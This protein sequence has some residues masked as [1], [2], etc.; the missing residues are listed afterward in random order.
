[1][2]DPPQSK[3]NYPLIGD[4]WKFISSPGL[5]SRELAKQCD[6]V[7]AYIRGLNGMK[8]TTV[9]HLCGNEALRAFYDEETVV[10]G[11]VH[12][13]LDSYM[14]GDWLDV[15]P[16]MNRGSH[17]E[18]KAILLKAIHSTESVNRF[19]N[20]VGLFTDEFIESLKSRILPFGVPTIILLNFHIR[21]FCAQVT[22]KYLWSYDVNE[23]LI[24]KFYNINSDLSE[25]PINCPIFNFYDGLEGARWLL[26]FTRKRL[27]EHQ[28]FQDQYNDTLQLLINATPR[29]TDDEIITEI[30]YLFY[31][32]NGISSIVSGAILLLCKN[33]NTEV[34]SKTMKEI[35][36]NLTFLQSYDA[37]ILTDDFVR[38]NFPYLENVVKET[39][40]IYPIEPLK[41]GTVIRDT[42]IK[43]FIIPK[44]SVVAAGL[45]ANGF[46]EERYPDPDSL[47]PERYEQE[48]KDTENGFDWTPFGGGQ[49]FQSHRCAGQ[50][51]VLRTCTY[52]LARLLSTFDFTLIN[53]NQSF[54]YSKW[55]SRPKDELPIKIQLK[56]MSGGQD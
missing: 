18:R 17:K 24:E 39:I 44:G 41:F 8:Y 9:Y 31:V 16:K 38:K 55:V 49:L 33:K 54:D 5:W 47:R 6:V 53:L 12:S 11:L 13:P 48:I 35:E 14:F 51:A 7:R 25:K 46:N 32:I 36:S 30:N 23:K 56:A 37:S 45:W 27:I 21:N 34:F 42:I 29:L 3:F 40:R 52:L 26:N 10:R 1:M 28:T 2:S 43:G 20:T 22:A 15:T 50:E 4:S 19:L